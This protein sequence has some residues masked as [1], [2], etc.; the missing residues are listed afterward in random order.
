MEPT[1]AEVHPA[2]V[3][4]LLHGHAGLGLAE[5]WLPL[6]LDESFYAS[7]HPG[8]KKAFDGERWQEVSP[9]EAPERF[10][11]CAEW[12]P[13]ICELI[14]RALWTE[15]DVRGAAL[16]RGPRGLNLY[17]LLLSLPV[18]QPAGRIDESHWVWW[19]CTTG[20]AHARTAAH[21]DL[22]PE[23][24]TQE[25]QGFIVQIDTRLPCWDAPT[26][27]QR[28]AETFLGETR[29]DEMSLLLALWD[30]AII[31]GRLVGTEERA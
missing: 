15:A 7:Y 26:F 24:P 17:P 21:H 27:P 16:L 29:S 10:R 31:Q 6:L 28:L 20:E 19:D 13:R 25:T 12:K 4:I 5:S 30:A 2:L 18:T 8:R 23:N 9:Q 22:P 11:F 1:L 14:V 3:G